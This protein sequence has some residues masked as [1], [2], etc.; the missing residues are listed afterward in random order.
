MRQQLEKELTGKEAAERV[1]RRGKANTGEGWHRATQGVRQ[2]GVLLC[3]L[4]D[5]LG[6]VTERLIGPLKKV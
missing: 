4:S 6:G 2:E 3:I 1:A 5:D